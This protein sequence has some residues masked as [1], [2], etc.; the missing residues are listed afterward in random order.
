VIAVPG[1]P[2]LLIDLA[3]VEG[4]RTRILFDMLDERNLMFVAS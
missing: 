4:I 3:I 1:E 2:L